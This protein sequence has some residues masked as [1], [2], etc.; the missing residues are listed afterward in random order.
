ME[1]GERFASAIP[2]HIAR[3]AV[4]Q[5]AEAVAAARREGWAQAIQVVR[6]HLDRA[7]SDPAGMHLRMGRVTALGQLLAELEQR[8]AAVN[9][10]PPTAAPAE[11]PY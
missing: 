3:K 9:V 4:Q 5:A 2:A 6:D 7:Q 11:P 8:A 1:R 10:L